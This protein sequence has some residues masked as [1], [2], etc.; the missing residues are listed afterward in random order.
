M[1][2]KIRWDV[3][4]KEDED[5]D[6]G[7]GTMIVFI[8][9]VLVAAVAAGVLISAAILVREQ[10]EEISADAAAQTATHFEIVTML[11]D[12][13]KESYAT[14]SIDPNS[15]NTGDGFM[16]IVTTNSKFTKTEDWTVTCVGE[17]SNG[18]IFRIQGSVSGTQTDYNISKG[19]YVSDN[20]EI[21]FTIFYGDMDF[22]L[23][24]DFEFQ[25][26]GL[27]MQKSIQKLELTLELGPGSPMINMSDVVIAITDGD[28]EA[29]LAY[30]KGKSNSTF[31][32]VECIRDLTGRWQNDTVIDT[33]ALV[34]V[35]IDCEAVGLNL[36]SGTRVTLDIIPENGVSL[37]ERFRTPS[38]Y[39]DRYIRLN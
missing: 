22:K 28:I 36:K 10:A 34:K 29:S 15:D 7:I 30:K 1:L 14:S 23:G 31:F 37:Y 27:E 11:G 32:D 17:E 5:A 4:L 33:G 25:T 26:K 39:T 20:N 18:G 16:S 19:K 2:K 3:S 24:D 12:R 6:V 21:G 35:I 13:G 38:G 9:L 8:A